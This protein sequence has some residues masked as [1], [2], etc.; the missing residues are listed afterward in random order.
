[1]PRS[2]TK[3]ASAPYCKSEC[4][5]NKTGQRNVPVRYSVL[6]RQRVARSG[7]WPSVLTKQSQLRQNDF[8][9][10]ICALRAWPPHVMCARSCSYLYNIR[11][12]RSSVSSVSGLLAIVRP[13]WWK[14]PKLWFAPS[15]YCHSDANGDFLMS[16]TFVCALSRQFMDHP[17]ARICIFCFIP[18]SVHP[19]PSPLFATHH[20]ADGP[21]E[22]SIPFCVQLHMYVDWAH[23]ERASRRTDGRR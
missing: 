23:D 14:I 4:S 21:H 17:N 8:D 11:R 16:I 15:C 22:H 12:S 18:T 13:M 20:I 1:M 19:A 2:T 5:S 10:V 7:R 3:S 6:T 9:W